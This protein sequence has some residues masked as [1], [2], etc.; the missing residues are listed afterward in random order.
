MNKFYVRMLS[1]ALGFVLC[2]GVASAQGSE[3][4]P[5]M[6][7]VRDPVS[8]GMGFTGV[9]SSS[10]I[11]YSSFVN[12]AMIP[13]SQL[14][15]DVGA[16]FQGWA[17]GGV[18]STNVAFGTAFRLG[19]NLGL[20]A[21]GAYQIGE[22]YE[23]FDDSGFQTGTGKPSDVLVNV[24]A[25]YRILDFLSVGVNARFASEK[26]SP[27]DSYSAFGADV[28]V[29][30]ALDGV[31]IS[32]GVSSVGSSISSASGGSF[33][34]PASATLGADY[35]KCFADVHGVE[36]ALDADYFFSGAF[37]AALGAQYSYDDMIFARA[38]YHLGS[39]SAVLPSFMTLGVGVKFAGFS[40]NFAYLLGD[41]SISNTLTVGIGYSF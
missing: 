12:S 8:A 41:E 35:S 19:D 20:S 5:F 22:K 24:G 26:L 4:L 16:S 15:G 2:A 30:L 10:R 39:E 27:D 32:A 6:R 31:R 9:A 17:P 38:G 28:F 37:T 34:I 25:G 23:M 11:A 29:A 7:I 21:G 3:A 18:K 40:A 1:F 36:L 33:S 13:F 14:K